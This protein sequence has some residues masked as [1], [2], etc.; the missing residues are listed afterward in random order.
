MDQNA[1]RIIVVIS[2]PADVVA[3][4]NHQTALAEL[5]RE[6]LGH[7]QAGKTGTNNEKIEHSLDRINKIYG[8]EEKP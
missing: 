3:L 1:T 2:I 7:C 8:T 5:R 6:A 4:I